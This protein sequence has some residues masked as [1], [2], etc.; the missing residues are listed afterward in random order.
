M[1]EEVEN[2][3]EVILQ[4][5][6]ER[7]H[8]KNSHEKE[9]FDNEKKYTTMIQELHRQF[10]SAKVIGQ[11]QI[12]DL[13]AEVHQKT[14]EN[15]KLRNKIAHYDFKCR[16]STL[17]S[18]NF[19]RKGTNDPK[20]YSPNKYALR[21]AKFSQFIEERIHKSCEKD[22]KV[23]TPRASKSAVQNQVFPSNLNDFREKVPNSPESPSSMERD[24]KFQIA[25]LFSAK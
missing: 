19:S 3:K 23:P 24:R 8:L 4:Y 7:Q 17:V 10:E 16:M 15:C 22:L 13:L 21:F 20:S 14:Q 12:N 9:L 2:Y 5:E 18:D 1:V 11:R 6:Q 25:G